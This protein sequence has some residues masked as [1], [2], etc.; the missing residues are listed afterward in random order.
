MCMGVVRILVWVLCPV[1][2]MKFSDIQMI[3][4]HKMMSVGWIRSSEGV[5]SDFR[6]SWNLV[7]V[8]I[9]FQITLD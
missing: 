7:C 9:S 4:S 6:C 8:A 5:F 3:L 2:L 1:K